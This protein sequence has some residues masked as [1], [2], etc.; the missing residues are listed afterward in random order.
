MKFLYNICS[1]TLNTPFEN[2]GSFCIRVLDKI[3]ELLY[4]IGLSTTKPIKQLTI[5]DLIEN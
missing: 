3:N 2:I 1:S 5:D 4:K